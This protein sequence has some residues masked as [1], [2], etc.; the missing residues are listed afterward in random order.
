MV[1]PAEINIRKFFLPE[2]GI[3]KWTIVFILIQP[4]FDVLVYVVSDLLSFHSILISLIR[5][6]IAVAVY[7]LLLSRKGISNTEKAVSLSLLF[8]F[9]MICVL[10]LINIREYFFS[11]SYGTLFDEVR[12]LSV[13]GYFLVLMF[14]LY[15]ILK[16]SSPV[17]RENIGKAIACAVCLISTLHLLAVITGTSELTYDSKF[18][19]KGW[20]VSSH[21]VGHSILLSL[22]IVIDVF[23]ERRLIRSRYRYLFFLLL[24]T[25]LFYIIGTKAPAFG[26]I[27]VLIIYLVIKAM[28]VI[29]KKDRFSFDH[30]FLLGLLLALLVT[31]PYTPANNNFSIQ[32]NYGSNTIGLYEQEFIYKSLDGYTDDDIIQA[33]DPTSFEMR[34]LNAISM[35]SGLRAYIFDSRQVQLRLNAYLASISPLRDRILGYGYFTLPKN[36][37][38][39]TD[40]FAL[41][42]SYG[43]AGFSLIIGIPFL[44]CLYWGIRM[45]LNIRRMTPLSWLYGMGMC[46][47]FCLVTLVGYTMFFAQTVFYFAATLCTA[48]VAFEDAIQT[49]M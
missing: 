43:I 42:F 44:F 18:G 25:S 47:G 30:L 32:N 36:I 37:W 40:T 1:V 6:L 11:G 19:F 24:A 15:F 5:P 46:L 34:T 35:I 8:A 9:G 2:S 17:D 4:L 48:V 45:L 26:L 14:D 23:F 3:V 22:P 7:F 20:S 16:S 13:Y 21:Y 41:F 38:V 10:H 31:L 49:G 29:F 33:Q 39:E 28:Y 27:I 12:H